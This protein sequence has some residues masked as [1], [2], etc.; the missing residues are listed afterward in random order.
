MDPAQ[1][2]PPGSPSYDSANLTPAAEALREHQERF[3][4]LAE[5]IQEIF[6]M[7]DAATMQAIYV[8]PAFEHITGRTCA[9]LLES[10]LSYRE[11]IHS[12]D[13]VR[14]LNALS[15]ARTTGKFDEEFRIT[16][17][18]GTIRWVSTR[19]FPIR[20]ARGN[21]YRL[22]GVVQDITDKRQVE[23]ALRESEDRYRDL[24]EHSQDLLC[25]HDLEGR[26]LSCN[27]APAR[28]L[29]YAVDELL[30]LSLRELLA[31]EVRHLFDDYLVKIQKD[32]AADGLMVLQTRTGERRL[33][34]YRNTLRTDGLA[35]VV[36]G[37]AHDVTERHRAEAALRKSEE[38]FRVAL[39]SSPVTVFNQDRDLR[40]TWVHNPTP[41]WSEK[42]CGG[43]TDAEIMDAD[44]ASRVMALK[45]RVLETGAGTRTGVDVTLNGKKYFFDLTLEPQFD[46]KG[47]LIGLT[48]ACM[49]VTEFLEKTERLQLLLEINSA[50]VSKLDIKDLFPTISACIRRLIDH[51]FAS[52]SVYDPE[53]NVMLNY[54]LDMISAHRFMD[55][56]LRVP[57]E[58][59]LAALALQEHDVKFFRRPEIEATGSGLVGRLFC[60]DV[61]SL[62]CIPINT[63]EGPICTLNLA[64]MSEN[65]FDSAD[66]YLMRQLGA[67]LAVALDNA[68]TYGALG[69][70][71][72]KLIEEKQ[73]LEREI[74]RELHFEEVIGSS[75]AVKQALQRAEMVAAGDSAIL[76]SGESGTGKELLARTIHRMSPRSHRS[77]LKLNCAALPVSLLEVELFGHEQEAFP[78]AVAQKI[79]VLELADTGTL[80]LDEVAEL[81]LDL[82]LRLLRAIEEKEF[83]RIGGSRTRKIDLRLIAA[84]RGDLAKRVA[85]HKFRHE[86]YYRLSVWPIFTT[87]LRE[88]REDIP[89]LVIHFVEK[90][91]QRL[92]KHIRVIPPTTIDALS[93]WNWPG[94]VRELENFIERSVILT[95]GMVLQAPIAELIPPYE[96]AG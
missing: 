71:N 14:V 41:A 70:I 58:E 17:P 48:G 22:A 10:P 95:R 67:Q 53:H 35:P 77:F 63:S 7:V 89:L 64:S 74:R 86:L 72:Q 24:V 1:H 31:P 26:L 6:W 38:R 92:K 88:R 19:G 37:M 3:R 55:L 57:M 62:C 32:G 83:E 33:W 65:A 11:I 68:N 59:S 56:D 25:T 12:D 90:H 91:S 46:S 52:V 16:R 78:G 29:G 49:D 42:R 75:P 45:R 43:K 44:D 13:R 34:E 93:N 50:L 87:P 18:D 60:H 39:K 36:R 81:P 30:Q 54:P 79:G 47:T 5:N 96:S 76:I 73:Y 66:L 84:T 51:D 28:I 82:Q 2:K 61:Q 94:N 20:D 80:F 9:S 21:T 4:Q 40:Y 23:S 85:E 15:E 8:N 27:P 69:H